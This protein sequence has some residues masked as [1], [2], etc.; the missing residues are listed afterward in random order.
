MTNSP[1]I[2]DGF[3][4]AVKEDGEEI[5]LGDIFVHMDGTRLLVDAEMHASGKPILKLRPFCYQT[6]QHLINRKQ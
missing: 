5:E 6:W 1:E 4:F 2:L 3:T